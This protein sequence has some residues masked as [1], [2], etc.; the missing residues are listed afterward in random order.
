MRRALPGCGSGSRPALR[1]VLVISAYAA[2]VRNATNASMPIHI[3]AIRQ[4]G[5]P[6]L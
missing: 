6:L 5:Q 1:E 4:A 2:Q 3:R